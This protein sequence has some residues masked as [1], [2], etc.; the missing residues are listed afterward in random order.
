MDGKKFIK[1]LDEATLMFER[2][3]EVWLATNSP[4]KPNPGRPLRAVPTRV[5]LIEFLLINA[6][7]TSVNYGR[8][9]TLVEIARR[10]IRTQA[11][12]SLDKH[13]RSLN[14]WAADFTGILLEQKVCP[15]TKIPI[16]VS[17]LLGRPCVTSH[18]LTLQCDIT[19]ATARS[20]LRRLARHQLAWRYSIGNTD[21]YLVLSSLQMLADASAVA[22]AEISSANSHSSAGSPPPP[23]QLEFP[24]MYG[25]EG[26]IPVVARNMRR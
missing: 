20:W 3:F 25:R 1:N 12:K 2:L 10:S 21:Y 9:G 19:A 26:Y 4:P 11:P 16:L 6:R 22:D 23:V 14:R 18:D 17:A 13:A 24:A 5:T 8:K 15:R 7:H